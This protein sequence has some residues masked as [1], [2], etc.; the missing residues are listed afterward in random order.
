[1]NRSMIR[2]SSH[3]RA[4][5]PTRPLVNSD[6]HPISKLEWAIIFAL[7]LLI[8]LAAAYFLCF[9]WHIGNGDALSRTANA[10]YVLYS[11]EPHLAAVGFVWPPLPSILQLP[12]LPLMKAFGQVA[13]TGSILSSLFGAASLALMNRLLADFKFPPMMRWI[14]V[15]LLQFHPNTLYLFGAG[16][17]EPVFLFFVIITLIGMNLMPESMRSWVMVGISLALAFLVRYESIPVLAAVVVAVIA[18]MWKTAPGWITKTEGWLLAILTPP[19]YAILLWIFFNWTLLGDPLYFYR[20]FYSLANASDIARSIG[21][22]HPLYLA[23]GNIIEAIKVGLTRCLE[24]NP[25]YPIFG[26]FALVSILRN[27]N[28]KG[29]GLFLVMLSVTA[30][31]ILQIY[32]GTLANWLRYWFYAAP[33]GLVMA[34]II[35]GNLKRNWRLPFYFLVVILFLAGTPLSLIAMNDKTVGSD[36]QRMSAMIFNPKNES[37]LRSKDWYWVNLNDAPTV[38]EEVDRLSE[39]GLVLV[40]SSTSFSVIMTSRHPE[41]MYITNDNNFF[42]VLANPIGTA[43]YILVLDPQQQ[44]SIFNVTYP[45]LFENGTNWAT[46]VWDS[47]PRTGAH[48]RIFKIHPIQKEN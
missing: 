46:L 40:D 28:R 17:A 38:A 2:S 21:L 41:R 44:L 20:S 31:S 8:N 37:A 24:Q 14:L 12:L 22:G 29:F 36:E 47:G 27:A 3:V 10:Y 15:G 19:I 11:R 23:W 16:M 33:F 45:T 5:H 32:L 1:M 30:F 48:W 34:G 39:K 42:K 18:Q 13:F 25:A 4:L 26:V 7:S 43:G 35:H 9:V 6:N